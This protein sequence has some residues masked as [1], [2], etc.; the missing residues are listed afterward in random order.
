MG[1]GVRKNGLLAA[2]DRGQLVAA[3]PVAQPRSAVLIDVR[4]RPGLV[5]EIAG[6]EDLWASRVVAVERRLVL[7]A[8]ISLSR[9]H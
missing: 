7:Q 9:G 8:A 5:G 4:Q 6:V 3:G 1:S 2:V